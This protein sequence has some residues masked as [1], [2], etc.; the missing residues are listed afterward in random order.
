MTKFGFPV[1]SHF[2]ILLFRSLVHLVTLQFFCLR[3]HGY[4]GY[5]LFD[6][7]SEP[8]SSLSCGQHL[9]VCLLPLLFVSGTLKQLEK[10]VVAF[11]RLSRGVMFDHLAEVPLPVR[12]IFICIGPPLPDVDYLEVGRSL[13]TLMA[14]KV[15]Q[16]Q[17]HKAQN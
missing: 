10:P 6:Q 17:S 2:F 16:C 3:Y 11:V 13:S 8:F 14:N 4:H 1:S 15:I 12:F 9:L 7:I 5:S